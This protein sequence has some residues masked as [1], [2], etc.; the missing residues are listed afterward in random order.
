M[1]D[2]PNRRVNKI[3][4]DNRED[5]RF[6]LRSQT[7]MGRK[8]IVVVE[9]LGCGGSIGLRGRMLSNDKFS[10]PGCGRRGNMHVVRRQVRPGDA[11]VFGR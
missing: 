10:C 11:V 6:V 2:I 4:D 1:R 8:L 5:R 9:C 3:V 7:W